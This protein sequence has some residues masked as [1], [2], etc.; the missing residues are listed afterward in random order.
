MHMSKDSN[1][2][3]PLLRIMGSTAMAA[4]PR[5]VLAVMRDPEDEDRHYLASLKMNLGKKPKAL[6]Y[7]LDGKTVLFEPDPIE[8][9]EYELFNLERISTSELG[10]AVEFL[11]SYLG[12]GGQ[13]G[14]DVKSH[15]VESED[16]SEST[17]K[18]AKAKLGI[19]SSKRTDDDGNTAWWWSLPDQGDQE[20]QDQG[21]SALIPLMSNQLTIR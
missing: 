9:S 17:L 21:A 16:G 14:T 4:M 1:Q 3:D 15:W 6:A 13:L 5:S 11:E 19:K 12:D 18:K 20:D 8:K 7:K 10:K 2:T